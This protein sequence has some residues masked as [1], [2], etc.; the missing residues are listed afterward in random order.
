MTQAACM[1]W[2]TPGAGY[3]DLSQY[4]VPVALNTARPDGD[5]VHE[6]QYGQTLWSI[7][8]EYGTTIEQLKRLNNLPDD[9][10]VSG[11]KLLVKKGATQPAPPTPTFILNQQIQTANPTWPSTTTSVFTSVPNEMSML[12]E[13]L[14]ANKVVIVAMIVSLSILVAAVV[15]FGKK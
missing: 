12:T 5:V 15:G 2:T 14:G 1:G 4:S 10:V 6:V 9:T 13:S 8:I 7:A 3:V 11:W